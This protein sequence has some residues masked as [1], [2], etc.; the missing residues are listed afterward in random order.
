[1]PRKNRDSLGRTPRPPVN[2]TL[3]VTPW[4]A[5]DDSSVVEDDG[6]NIYTQLVTIFAVLCVA[7]AGVAL[8]AWATQGFRL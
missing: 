4:P 8:G 7:A 5:A 2:S 6:S 1:M 3:W